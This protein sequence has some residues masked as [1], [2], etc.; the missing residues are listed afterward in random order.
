MSVNLTGSAR[1]LGVVPSASFSHQLVFR[2]IWR[3]LAKRGHDLVVI[4]TDP[5]NDPSLNITEIDVSFAYHL[6]NVKHSYMKKF[7]EYRNNPYRLMSLV[8]DVSLDICNEELLHP[9]VQALLKN[10]TEYFDLVI[11]EYFHPVMFGLAERFKCPFIGATPFDMPNIFLS[12]L[13]VSTHPVAYPDILLPFQAGE[14]NFWE[15]LASTL[16]NIMMKVN[17]FTSGLHKENA[18]MARHFGKNLP[19]ID[20]LMRKCSMVFLNVNPAFNIRPLGPS[21]VNIGDGIHIAPTR[22][23]P[24]VLFNILIYVFIYLDKF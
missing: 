19:P 24:K 10:E 21:F 7:E 6:W 3:E 12:V 23:L 14:M 13:G 9:E 4:T 2:P 22:P 15:R 17:L 18:F 16:F 1:I 8:R 20:E 11:V 5:E